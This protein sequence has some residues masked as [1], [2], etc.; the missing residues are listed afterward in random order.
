MAKRSLDPFGRSSEQAGQIIS[1]PEF[2]TDSAPGREQCVLKQDRLTNL[3]STNILGG[4]YRVGSSP[5]CCK[6]KSLHLLRQCKQ[7]RHMNKLRTEHMSVRACFKRAQPITTTWNFTGVVVNT[8]MDHGHPDWNSHNHSIFCLKLF[9]LREQ[10]TS[11]SRPQC[12]VPMS[13]KSC[14]ETPRSF[15]GCRS[16]L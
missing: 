14:L 3:G 13:T 2:S 11:C 10:A 4:C 6:Q 9:G 7:T 15:T 8:Y 16:A 1:P 12:A 5:P